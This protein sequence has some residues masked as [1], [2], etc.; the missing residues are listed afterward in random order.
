LLSFI[1]DHLA[2]RPIAGSLFCVIKS[3]P[4][5][6]SVMC[7]AAQMMHGFR[8]IICADPKIAVRNVRF[9]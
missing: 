3:Q 2:A 9:L 7:D 8:H 1:V 6:G 5:L 4:L